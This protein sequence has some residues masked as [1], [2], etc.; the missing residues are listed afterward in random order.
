MVITWGPFLGG[1]EL[2]RLSYRPAVRR[3]GVAAA[4]LGNHSRK[5]RLYRAF[6]ELGRRSAAPGLNPRNISQA[7]RTI[8]CTA[9]GRIRIV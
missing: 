3:H 4:R 7:A 5:N 6:R 2:R 9:M 1:G 8:S